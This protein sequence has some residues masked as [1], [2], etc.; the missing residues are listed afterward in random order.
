MKPV[1]SLISPTPLLKINVEI[2]PCPLGKSSYF[3]YKKP[4]NFLRFFKNTYRMSI[5][6]FNADTI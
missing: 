4:K 6:Y 5:R 2:L 3:R 1:L